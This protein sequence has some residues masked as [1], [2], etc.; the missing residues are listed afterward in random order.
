MARLRGVELQ[1]HCEES[2]V[3]RADA[4]RL[5]QILA[6]LLSNAVKYNRPHGRVDVQARREGDELRID[7]CDTGLGMNE[8]Q[9][10]QLFQPF[11]RLGAERTHTEGTGLGL[12]ITRDLIGLMG[13]R[14]QVDSEPGRG[15]RM[16]VLL[17]PG[18]AATRSSP[19]LS[20][21]PEAAMRPVGRM[22]RVL[23][24]EDNA[25]N[26][27]LVEAML[28]PLP[29]VSLRVAEDGA[30]AL[31]SVR[32]E[33]PDLLLLDMNL[34]DIDGCALL[35]DLRGVGGLDSVP[36]VAVSADA[37]PAQI[38]RARRAGFHAYWTKPLDVSQ[39]QRDVQRLLSG[40]A[41]TDAT[42]S[43]R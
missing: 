6:N 16:S 23:Y 5:S 36:A 19:V 14:L 7:V 32:T 43:G 1:L 21:M 27:L 20:P 29:D 33:Q 37:M 2:L 42:V 22:A 38:E 41:G 30:A 3:V 4:A 28:Q 12:V 25:V 26:A 18:A 15:T 24:V 8:E 40:A 10:A 39:V 17:P 35:A 9:R 11:N 34:P 13:G 31:V